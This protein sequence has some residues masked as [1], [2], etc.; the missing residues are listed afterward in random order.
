MFDPDILIIGGIKAVGA[1][2]KK[3]IVAP[4]LIT[5]GGIPI[6]AIVLLIFLWMLAETWYKIDKNNGG[7]ASSKIQRVIG[8]AR[9]TKWFIIGMFSVIGFILAL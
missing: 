7:E 2:I 3:T 8:T 5:I 1:L 6:N 9:F 4:F